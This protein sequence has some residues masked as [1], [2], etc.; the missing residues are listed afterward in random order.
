MRR[1]VRRLRFRHLELLA[2]L[3]EVTTMRAA[4]NRMQL[5]QPAIT[6]M[7]QEIESIFDARLFVR[8]ARGVTANEQGAKLVAHAIA[9]LNELD[10]TRQEIEISGVQQLDLLRL[11]AFSGSRSIAQAFAHL[12]QQHP[13]VRVTIRESVIGELFDALLRGELDCLIGSL[14]PE[15]LKQYRMDSLRMSSVGEE[16]ARVVAAK[17][18][19]WAR[20]RR[21]GWAELDGARWVLPPRESLMRRALIR[22]YL[23]AGLA[24]PEPIV[25]VMSPLTIRS[26]LECG[27]VELGLMRS[28]HAREEERLGVLKAIA[29]PP[30]R[31]PALTVFTRREA[32]ARTAIVNAMTAALRQLGKD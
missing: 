28:G 26:M 19:S 14:P 12:T 27:G 22:A 15:E 1:V 23:D 17:D 29:V 10:G 11:G 25:E 30:L 6:R 20:R 32:G 3:D 21:I 18:S 5:T 16:Q 4:A 2:L 7:L 24:P 8:G 31:M 13:G 9:L